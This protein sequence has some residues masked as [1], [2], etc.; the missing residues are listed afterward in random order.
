MVALEVNRLRGFAENHP[1]LEFE[2]A[3]WS[4]LSSGWA[5]EGIAAK[6]FSHYRH[7]L[8]RFHIATTATTMFD[9]T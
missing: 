4:T 8:R 5:C 7:G 9:G 1:A 3:R 2:A 6:Y